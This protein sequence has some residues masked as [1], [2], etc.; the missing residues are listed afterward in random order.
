MENN[1]SVEQFSYSRVVTAQ[2]YNTL[3]S[4]LGAGSNLISDSIF[5]FFLELFLI[6]YWTFKK[7]NTT[8]ALYVIQVVSHN[9]ILRFIPSINWHFA[10]GTKRS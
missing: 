1:R 9:M 3:G 6:C 10:P 7:Q 8:K 2:G 5:F 4:F